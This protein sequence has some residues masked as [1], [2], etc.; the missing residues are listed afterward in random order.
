M[1]ELIINSEINYFI[2]CVLE[3][4]LFQFGLFVVKWV[5]LWLVFINFAV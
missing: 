2:Y 5:N 4:M 1:K 3:N